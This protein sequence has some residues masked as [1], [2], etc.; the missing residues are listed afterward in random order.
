VTLASPIIPELTMA[1]T[2]EI[3]GC[4]RGERL[5]QFIS[6]RYKLSTSPST[7]EGDRVPW[8]PVLQ[9]EASGR[10]FFPLHSKALILISSSIPMAQSTTATKTLASPIIPELI[11]PATE[12]IHGCYRGGSD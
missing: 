11:V 9:A 6:D 10:E 12:E 5:I 7:S 1:A 2:E 3:H 8:L 4:Y